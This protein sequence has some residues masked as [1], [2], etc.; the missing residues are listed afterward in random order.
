MLRSGLRLR[1]LS[2]VLLLLWAGCIIL[3]GQQ[4]AL[5][6]ASPA[7]MEK[8]ESARKAAHAAHDKTAEA[9][10]LNQMGELNVGRS[11]FHNATNN[12][13]QALAL[14]RS[15]HDATGQVAALNG[16]ALCYRGQGQPEKALQTYQDALT[17]ATTSGDPHSRAIALIGIAGVENL[18]GEKQRALSDLNEALAIHQKTGDRG[19]EAAVLSDL[20]SIYSDLGERRKALEYF[21]RALPLAREANDRRAEATAL[22]GMGNTYVN[23]GEEQRALENLNQALAIERATNAR[24][25]EATVLNSLGLLY[26]QLGDPQKA[27]EYFTQALAIDRQ[28]NKRADEAQALTNMGIAYTSLKE[29]QQALDCQNQAL[30]IYREMKFVLGQGRVLNNIG[31]IYGNRGD[32]R[33][34]LEY[35]QQALPLLRQASFRRG[36]ANTLANMA[37]MYARLGDRANAVA[38]LNQALPVAVTVSDPLLESRIL[39]RLMLMQRASQPALAILYGKQAV[40]LLQTVRGN[41][42]GMDEDVQRN[43]AGS[44]AGAYHALADLLIS[45]G[46]L[47]EAQQ[48]LDLL[49]QQEYQEYVRGTAS[50][51]GN[52]ASPMALTPAETQAETDYQRSTAQLIAKSQQ[53]EELRANPTRTAE[54]EKQY[55]KLSQDLSA[56][57]SGLDHYYAELYELLGKDSNANRQIAEVKGNTSALQQTIAKMPHTVGLYTTVGDDK[58]RIL[59]VTGSAEVAREYPITESELAQK[60]E[61]LQQV[62]RNASADPRPMAQQLYAVLIGPVKADLDQAGALTLVWSLDGVLRYVPIAALY[63]GKQ[64]LVQKYATVTITPASFPYLNESPKVGAMSTVAMGISQQYEQGLPGLPAVASELKHVVHD[65][66]VQG[67]NGVL[68]GTILLNDQFTEKGMENALSTQHTVVHIA[69]HFVFQPGDDRRSYLLLSSG[70]G[71]GFHLTVANFRDNQQLALNDTDLLTLSAC[72]TGMNGEASNGREVDGLGTTAQLKGAKAV[73]SSLWSV[74]DSSTGEL[75]GDFYKRWATGGG[76]VQKVEALRQ[77]QLDLLLG[78]LGARTSPGGRGS[79]PVT[80]AEARAATPGISGYAHPYYWAPFVLMGNWK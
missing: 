59:V 31:I 21:E 72:E 58:L 43:F 29:W 69:S 35:Y 17:L 49:K 34:A 63:D 53:W 24:G 19:G 41:I 11:D 25:G 50:G 15:A 9:K 32:A 20:G 40:G 71:A 61:N 4:D 79:R 78:R 26:S 37:N 18:V 48:V 5:P 8:L 36:E 65:P 10:A 30:P 27:L 75:M 13:N 14:S 66:S 22:Q 55:E 6:A 47:R 2:A 42:R 7:Q 1:L 57:S 23:L 12:F 80:T 70:G 74:N 77:A 73:I 52:T 56:A 67:A 33:K 76:K 28:D 45:Q 62:L 60:V 38:Y 54:Q 51:S 64:Y 39:T 44:Q 3:F 16:I 68:P 46:R